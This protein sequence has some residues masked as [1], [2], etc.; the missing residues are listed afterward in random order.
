MNLRIVASVVVALT[1]LAATISAL[2]VRAAVLGLE[3]AA[4]IQAKEAPDVVALYRTR[5]ASLDD[6]LPVIARHLEREGVGVIL[7][8][9][10]SRQGYDGKGRF[11][12][13]IP[14]SKSGRRP[15]AEPTG[16][17]N[18]FASFV[19]VS[20]GAQGHR[21]SVDGILISTAV[22]VSAVVAILRQATLAFAL[23]F[24]PTTLASLWYVRSVRREALAALAQTTASLRCLAEG[25]FEPRIVSTGDRTPHG[26]LARAYNAAAQTVASALAEREAVEREMRRFVAD[27]GHELR[28]PLAI[29][30]GYVELL[31]SGAVT[32]RAVTERVYAGVLAEAARL[33]HL[34]DGLIELAVMDAAEPTDHGTSG[35]R[36]ELVAVL[37]RIADGL[38]TFG[39]GPIVIDAPE[40]CHVRGSQDEVVPALLNVIEN[41]VKY[42]PGS[43]VRV[44]VECHAAAVG[45]TVTDCGPGMLPDELDNVFKRFYR[46]ERRGEIPGSGLGL[47]IAKRALEHL[48]G[49]IAIESAV[50]TGTTVRLSMPVLEG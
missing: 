40:E 35:D 19:G 3:R 26:E 34:I 36:T 4:A 16:F 6:A 23:V 20:L 46:G 18:R 27:A 28:T 29:V 43:E 42:A 13:T 1:L 24:V 17:V 47:A 39:G 9:T 31:S 44:S 7:F 33:Q 30:I 12:M 45:V 50:G 37:H 5:Y 32:N 25:D 41:A 38:Q 48:G 14:E 2:Y 15:F 10:R 8:N 49:T 21:T 11:D 22:K